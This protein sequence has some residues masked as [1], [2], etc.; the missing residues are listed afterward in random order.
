MDKKP[1]T[2]DFLDNMTDSE[3]N[4]VTGMVTELLD[5]TGVD[6]KVNVKFDEEV[7][8]LLVSI[9]SEKNV[10]LLIGGRGKTINSIQ[11]LVSSMIRGTLGKTVR[12]SVN[13]GDWREKEM[14]KLEELAQKT[15]ERAISLK[16]DQY[17]YNLNPAERRIVHTLLADNGDVY[18]ESVGEGSERYLIV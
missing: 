12:V 7:K 9:D 8:A 16:E 14:E 4:K 5:L 18:T 6:Y 17:L 2:E 11:R 13:V 10:G 1:I 3:L 15:A